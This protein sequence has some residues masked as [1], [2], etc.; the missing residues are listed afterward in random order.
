MHAC[1]RD[2]SVCTNVKCLSNAGKCTYVYTRG[3]GALSHLSLIDEHKKTPIY[4]IR[5]FTTTNTRAC[6]CICVYV[7]YVKACEIRATIYALSH[8]IGTLAYWKIPDKYTLI[9]IYVYFLFE[10]S[11]FTW[12]C[13]DTQW[14]SAW[15]ICHM[16]DSCE[17]MINC[18][19]LQHWH[20]LEL[21]QFD[22][23]DAILVWYASVQII[24]N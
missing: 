20:F 19:V 3:I 17:S 23:A 5:R 1:T 2:M 12:Q 11:Y 15:K 13:Y 9:S 18:T 16:I 22:F 4:T 6:S 8:E 24:Q 10:K 7:R 14:N 21:A